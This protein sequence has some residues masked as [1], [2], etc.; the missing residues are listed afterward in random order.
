MERKNFV[1]RN[2]R[3]SDSKK[4]YKKNSTGRTRAYHK[5]GDSRG[6]VLHKSKPHTATKPGGQRPNRNKNK[7]KRAYSKNKQHNG[8]NKQSFSLEDNFS[9]APLYKEDLKKIPQI[10]PGVVRVIPICG[11][12]GVGTNMTVIEYG[13]EMIVI[14]IGFGFSN[15]DLPGINYTI[16]NIAYL[17][18]LKHKIKAVVITHGHMDHV[19]G[20]PFVIENLG[21]PPIYTREFGAMFIKTRLAEFPEIKDKVDIR[22][23]DEH[24][25]VLPLSA[26]LKVKFFGLTHSIPDS[27]GVIVYTPHGGIVSTGDVRVENNDGIP[28][29]KEIDQYSFFKNEDIILMTCDSTGVPKPGWSLSEETVKKNIDKIIKDAKGRLFIG[30]FSSQ[31]ERML[32]FLESAKKHG[33]HVVIEGRSMKNNMQIARHLDL[34][35]FSH[36][37]PIE[38]AKDHPDGKLVIFVTGAQ[39]EQYSALDRISRGVHKHFKLVPTDTVVLSSSVVPGNDFSVKKLKDNLYRGSYHIVTYTDNQVHASGHGKRDELMWIHKQIPYKYFMPIHGDHYMLQI[40][41]RLAQ[42]ELKVARDRVIVPE[43]GTIVEIFKNKG[44]VTAKKLRTK[45]PSDIVVVDGTYQGPVRKVLMDDRKRLSEEGMFVVVVSLDIK[46]GGLKKSPDIISRGFVYLR[47]SQQLLKGVRSLIL[48]TVD[49][50]ME[51]RKGKIDFEEIKK[52]LGDKITRYL[53]KK[54]DKDPIVI[55]VVLGV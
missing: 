43:N 5:P 21:F 23:I 3:G 1:K 26:N 32:S 46:K 38:E 16:P 39:G 6:A 2:N 13:D 17:E 9:L 11:V 55:P 40:H 51:K 4:D 30:A 20:I 45:T 19:G 7:Q 54:T 33:K 8:K 25:G 29:D 12:D 41:A 14:D 34:S 28:T 18:E 47:E 37:I 24:D 49:K 22:I 36:V 48:K 50:Y 15:P 27:T 42:E 53:R 35:D 10:K 44:M 52:E 31:V